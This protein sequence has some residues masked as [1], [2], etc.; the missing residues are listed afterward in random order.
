MKNT[1]ALWTV[2]LLLSLSTGAAAAGVLNRNTRPVG[3]AA[4]RHMTAPPQATQATPPQTPAA[5]Q[6]QA[7]AAAPPAPGQAKTPQ[8]KSREEYDAFN[9]MA[10]EKDLNKRISLAEAFLQKYSNSDFKSMAYVAEMQSYFQLN[11]SDEAAAAAM[12]AL[13]SDPDNLDALTFLSYVFPFTF[14]ADAPDAASK[15][16]RADSDARHGLEVLQKLPKPANVTDEQFNQAVKQKRAVFNECIGFVALQRKDYA[17]A[18]TASKAAAEDAPSDV[19][20]FYRLGLA[21]IYST[22]PDYDHAIWYI[23]RAVALAQASKNPAGDE[24]NKFLKRAYINYHGNDQG[25]SDIITQA[26]AS[27]NPPDGFKVA[28]MEIPKPTGDPNKDAFNTMTFALKLG[29][30]KAQKTWDALKGQTIELGGA[31]DSV[32]KAPEGAGTLVRIDILDQSKATDGVYDIELKDTTQ[33]NAKNLAKG[34]LLRFKGTADSYTATPNLILTLVGEV[35]TELP[36]KPAAKEK[37][38]PTKTGTTTH[39]TTGATKKK[40]TH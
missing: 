24:I 8:W 33:P 39:K 32:E 9:A 16:S 12:K 10:T 19:Y 31:V 2:T 23:S 37:P 35:V 14:K 27:V 13:G 22:P 17:A 11:K 29:G 40:P 20:T 28:A 7:P 18:I 15:L 36:D 34:D 4:V 30:E 3:L 25:L 21:Y 1:T 5:T 6:P 38:K 26:A